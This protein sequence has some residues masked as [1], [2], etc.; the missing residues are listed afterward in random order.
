MV[1]SLARLWFF[2]LRCGRFLGFITHASLAFAV[3]IAGGSPDLKPQ[4]AGVIPFAAI[5]IHIYYVREQLTF[6]PV[7][8]KGYVGY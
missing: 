6:A 5:I 2:I 7:A 4:I 1:A 8:I 3:G